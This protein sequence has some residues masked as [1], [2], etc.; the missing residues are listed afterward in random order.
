MVMVSAQSPTYL[1]LFSFYLVS[2]SV[3]CFAKPDHTK[4]S[5]IHSL[6]SAPHNFSAA[7]FDFVLDSEGV[8]DESRIVYI[9]ICHHEVEQPC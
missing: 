6:S 5:T 9:A 8:I 4:N 1:V 7:S 3:N 2:S